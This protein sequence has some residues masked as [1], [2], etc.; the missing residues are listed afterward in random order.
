MCGRAIVAYSQEQLEPVIRNLVRQTGCGRQAWEPHRLPDTYNYAPGQPTLTL[1]PVGAR[2]L[3]W[4]YPSKGKS[5]TINARVEKV[6]GWLRVLEPAILPINAFIEFHR[7]SPDQRKQATAFYAPQALLPLASLYDS[8]SETFVVLTEPAEAPV[9]ATH[10]RQPVIL[11]YRGL[12]SWLKQKQLLRGE[13]KLR[14]CQLDS[15]ASDPRFNRR[16]EILS[17]LQPFEPTQLAR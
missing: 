7:A 14:S 9:K 5:R 16:E 8:E 1:V 2:W 13:P 11:S 10:H 15:R 17:E 6:M 3:Q 4:G 12:G